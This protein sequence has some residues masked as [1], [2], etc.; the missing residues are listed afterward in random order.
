MHLE[1]IA[2]SIVK[3]LQKAGA[4]AYFAGGYVRDRLMGYPSQDIDIVTSFP[5]E[6]IRPLFTKTVDVGAQFGIL[7]VIEEGHRFEVATFRK[8]KGYLDGRRPTKI[9]LT[10]PKEDAK[11][12]DFTIN[13]L[14][15]DPIS[16]IIYDFVEGKKDI[17]QKTIRAIGNP[18][19]RFLEDRL[20]MLRAIRYATRFQF[21]I[22]HST[23]EAIKVH[24]STLFPSVSVERVLNE[25]EKME[26]NGHLK[27]GLVEMQR[28]NLLQAIFPSLANIDLIEI[29]RRLFHLPSL[30]LVLL[31]KELLSHLSKEEKLSSI[32][33]LRPKN[34]DMALL[35]FAEDLEDLLSSS[36]LQGRIFLYASPYFSPSFP[37]LS[38]ELQ[39]LALDEIK[40]YDYAILNRKENRSIIKAD[41]LFKLGLTPGP[42][43]GK[44]LK[45]AERLS[46]VL[47]TEEKELIL[48][49]LKRFLP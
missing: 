3:K 32:Q 19:D 41:D 9:E 49:H 38:K 37:L 45:E 13:G 5:L 15:F 43:L 21:Q 16:E 2:Q 22:E 42:A 18:H 20:R 7:L 1:I 46:I 31:L 4:I 30:P 34:E 27:E 36:D 23:Q 6:K 35:I 44:A 11:R 29:E 39:A 28:L 8:E 12:R 24:A 25:L 48:E 17:Q 33:F 40:I 47:K 26:K 14:F 10:H